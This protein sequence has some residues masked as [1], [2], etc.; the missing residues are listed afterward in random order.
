M[1]RSLLTLLQPLASPTSPPALVVFAVSL[2]SSLSKH[3]AGI[4]DALVEGGVVD[5]LTN[6][7]KRDHEQV[8]SEK[9]RHHSISASSDNNLIRYD[10]IKGES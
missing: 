9:H 10:T 7:L 4:A 2:I 8:S 5:M 6:H 1:A 3:L